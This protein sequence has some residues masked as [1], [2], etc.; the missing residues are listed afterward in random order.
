MQDEWVPDW[1]VCPVCKAKPEHERGQ[2]KFDSFF[3]LMRH[4]EAVHP[5]ETPRGDN[6]YGAYHWDNV[7]ASGD[8]R[9][10]LAE[11]VEDCYNLDLW[12]ERNGL[13]EKE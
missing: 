9:M 13:V 3:L 10:E 11:G 2:I 4:W 5:N 12:C 8:M 6:S 7:I 1:R